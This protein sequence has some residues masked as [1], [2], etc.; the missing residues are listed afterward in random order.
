MSNAPVR[1]ANVLRK[2]IGSVVIAILITVEI[3]VCLQYAVN[4]KPRPWLI[5]TVICSCLLIDGLCVAEIFFVRNMSSRIII[6]LVNF[7]LLLIICSAVGDSYLAI[8]YCVMLTQIYINVDGLRARVAMLIVSC[9]LFVIT[10][11]FGWTV[12][13]RSV[14][15][16]EALAEIISGCIIGLIVLL[17]HFGA[18][19]FGIRYY[20][21]NRRLSAALK[22]TDASRAQLQEAYDKLEETALYEE[23]NR[24][25]RDIHD[26]A[27]HSITAVIMQTEAA[28][29]LIDSDPAAAKAKVISA[30][31]QAKHALEQMRDSVHL[32]AGRDT[33]RSIK[34][35]L[36]MIISQTMDGTGVKVRS[37]IEDIALDVDRR[38]FILN[39]VKECFANGMRH[40]GATAFFVE[41]KKYGGTVSLLISDNGSGFAEGCKEGFGLRGIREK[42]NAIHGSLHYGSEE[43]EGAEICVTFPYQ[44]KKAEEENND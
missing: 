40:G 43:D 17:V 26:N 32:L 12:N 16:G 2:V 24:I 35:D 23:R 14:P 21:T 8:L 19:M 6:Y 36:E 13:H 4:V 41:L 39:T 44:D 11:T 34:T 7:A 42:A 1:S 3:V 27:G 15:T 5:T 33:A 9:F 20:R 37:D 30:N 38:R 25:A 10:F 28:K 22:E 18:A 31:I 29:L